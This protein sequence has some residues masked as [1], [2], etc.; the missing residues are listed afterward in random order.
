MRALC[1]MIAVL[2]SVAACAAT[3]SLAPPAPEWADCEAATNAALPAATWQRRGHF[4]VRLSVAAGTNL[5]QVAFGRDADGDG[6]LSYEETALMIGRGPEEVFFEDVAERRW[7]V[8]TLPPPA[9]RRGLGL[10][11]FLN[12]AGEPT[13]LL[14]TNEAGVAVFPGWRHAPPAWCFDPSWDTVRVVSAGPDDAEGL[15]R[16]EIAPDGT[17]CIMR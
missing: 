10:R 4:D 15:A 14:A 17:V 16:V 13:G 2:M 9:G 8:E 5:L 11:V 12:G 7:Y 3:V 1:T 6:K